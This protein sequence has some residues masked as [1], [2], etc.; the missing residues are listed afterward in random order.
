VSTIDSFRYEVDAQG[1]WIWSGYC[2]SNGYARIY[3]RA[4]R[5]IEW[6]H[7]YSYEQ[8]VE[9]IRPGYEID[10]MCEVTNCVNPDHLQQLTHREHCRVT[11]ERLGKVDKQRRAA[12]LRQLGMTYA[13]IADALGYTSKTSAAD[14]VNRA[15]KLGL[16]DADDIPRASRLNDVE[17]NDIAELVSLGVPQAIVAEVY[18][19]DDSQV[20][21]VSRGIHSG[22]VAR[23]GAA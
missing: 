10:H 11:M 21:R 5:R 2:D 1:C 16:V 7:R 9:P 8:H 14:A 23:R 19:I 6:A 17:R 15:I 13:E 20:S 4:N 12:H 22:H 18:G 3:D